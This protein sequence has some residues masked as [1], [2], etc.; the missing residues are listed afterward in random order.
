MDWYQF[1]RYSVL[2]NI[3]SYLPEDC[4]S[5]RCLEIAENLIRKHWDGSEY[6]CVAHMFS[7]AAT[8]LELADRMGLSDE[9]KFAVLIAGL[10][11]DAGRRAVDDK[12]NVEVAFKI[13]EEFIEY[14]YKFDDEFEKRK[15]KGLVKVGINGT[16]YPSTEPIEH[17]VGKVLRDADFAAT[18]APDNIVHEIRQALKDEMQVYQTDYSFI[19]DQKALL[20]VT[21]D[22][23]ADWGLEIDLLTDPA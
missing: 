16:L 13:A 15:I 1:S 14:V 10:F 11:H 12:I 18:L 20:P 6:H 22:Y 4:F 5:D 9:D 21:V 23:Y 17:N 3:T 8:G 7:V 2:L 19:V